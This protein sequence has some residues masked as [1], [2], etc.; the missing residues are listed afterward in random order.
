MQAQQS[1][2]CAARGWGGTA[3][4]A[5][6]PMPMLRG[7]VPEA[8]DTRC[9]NNAVAEGGGAQSAGSWRRCKAE[10]GSRAL[11]EGGGARG[12]GSRRRH[13]ALKL[14]NKAAEAPVGST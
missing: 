6:A 5:R 14:C 2:Y 8:Q 11:V 12:E 13:S 4:G 9:L 7:V 1:D 10:A 3:L